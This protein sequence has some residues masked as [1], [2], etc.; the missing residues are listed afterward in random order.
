[1]LNGLSSGDFFFRVPFF[2][3]FSYV[4]EVLNIHM[5]ED[6]KKLTTIKSIKLKFKKVF[7]KIPF[8]F[9]QINFSLLEKQYPS[10]KSTFFLFS[11]TRTFRTSST[12][13]L[14][15]EFFFPGFVNHT[16]NKQLIASFQLMFYYFI[17]HTVSFFIS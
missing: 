11:F 6:Y 12:S 15:G 16:A 2:R 8:P 13:F 3:T 7:K 4:P 1:M 10:K 9:K 14:S 5:N 17:I